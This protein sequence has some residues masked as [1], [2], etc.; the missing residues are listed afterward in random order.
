MG[1]G[2]GGGVL[3]VRVLNTTFNSNSI[4]AIY[5]EKKTQPA[6]SHW[7]TLSHNIVSSTPRLDG[8][9]THNS[10]SDIHWLHI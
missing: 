7:Q 10:S 4:S 2:V 6:T 8:I 1:A 5:P 3:G 9:G